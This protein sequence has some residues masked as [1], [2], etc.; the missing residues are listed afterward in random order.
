MLVEDF[1]S[2]LN[3][4]ALYISNNIVDLYLPHLTTAALLVAVIVW[5]KW[6]KS[7]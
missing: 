6:R 1:G 2:Y 4:K 3:W 5:R 7:H